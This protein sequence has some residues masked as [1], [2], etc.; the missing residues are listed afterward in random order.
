MKIYL[1]S[2]DENIGWDTYDSFVVVCKDE[3]TARRARP[4]EEFCEWSEDGS[5]VLFCYASGKKEIEAHG[6]GS[7][8]YTLA[9]VKVQYVGIADEEIYKETTILCSSFNAG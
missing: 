9:V 4:D 2:Q 7:W 5:H 8:A 3:E 6:Y 1:V